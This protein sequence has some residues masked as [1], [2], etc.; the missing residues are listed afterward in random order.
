[1]ILWLRIRQGPD[2]P[3]ARAFAEWL[4]LQSAMSFK[5]VVP[6]GFALER[7]F[8][9]LVCV[10]FAGTMMGNEYDWRTVGVVVGRGVRRWH[11]IFA[12]TV[13]ALLFTVTA[14][15]VA[16]SA[17]MAASAWFSH[18]YGLP[19]GTFDGVRLWHALGSFVRTAFVVFPFVFLALLCAVTWRSAGQAV[20]ASLGVYFTES[21][22]TGLLTNA[23]GWLSHVPE[24]LLNVNGD[25]IMHANGVLTDQGGGGPFVFGS[26]TAPLWRA[27][28]IL[29]AWMFGFVLLFAWQFQRRDIQE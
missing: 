8:A 2:R 22:F 28:I 19:Y 17:A 26:G 25:A 14:V 11:F 23:R 13:I 29:L 5:N 1:M 24:A 10:I 7:F 6:Y 20:G 3:S 27:T 4:S 15:A 16:F 21:I 9:T 18:L 12:K